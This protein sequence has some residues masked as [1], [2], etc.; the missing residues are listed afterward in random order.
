MFRLIKFLIVLGLGAYLGFG[1][2]GMMM[3]AECTSG[4]GQWTG[5]VCID[6]GASQWARTSAWA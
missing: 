4:E 6:N 2:K 3:K 5:S 1:A